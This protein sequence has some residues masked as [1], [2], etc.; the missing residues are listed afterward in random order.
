[1]ADQPFLTDIK[2]LRERARQHIENGAVTEG[3][4][5]D[6]ETVVKLLNE[7]LATEIVCV[8]R[9]KRHYFMA[10]GIHAEGVAA[11]FLEHAN[12][13]QGHADQIAQ[14]IVQLQGAPNFNPEGLLMRSHAEYVEGATLTDMIKEDLVAERIAIDSYREMIQYFGNEDP[15]SRRMLEGILAVEEEHADDL[16]S[17][18]ENMG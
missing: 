17:L 10:T 1:V 18:L 7:A 11:E 16:V 15:T 5:A 3:Y 9:Y 12:D 2:T 14:R 8:L 13:E 6:R 4:K